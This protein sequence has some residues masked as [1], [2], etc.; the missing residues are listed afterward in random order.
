MLHA[1]VNK[2]DMRNFSLFQSEICNDYLCP[3]HSILN[4]EQKTILIEYVED[5]YLYTFAVADPESFTWIMEYVK[6]KFNLSPD[7]NTNDVEVI[8]DAVSGAVEI[9]LEYLITIRD[10]IFCYSISEYNQH[11]HLFSFYSDR[12]EIEKLRKKIKKE[13]DMI[14]EDKRQ[15]PSFRRQQC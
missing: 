15:P 6:T 9:H 10:P 4:N 3:A 8:R 12:I 14:A 13:I 11:K 2:Q 1:S 5:W 7:D